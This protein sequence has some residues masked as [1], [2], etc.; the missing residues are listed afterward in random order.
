M[1]LYGI[2]RKS[3]ESS[4]FHSGVSTLLGYTVCCNTGET[5][6]GRDACNQGHVILAIMV[7]VWRCGGGFSSAAANSKVSV[8]EGLALIQARR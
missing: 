5:V 3:L 6:Y 7:S 4:D 2:S 1:T 8:D